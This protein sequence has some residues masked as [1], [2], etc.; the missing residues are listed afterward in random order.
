M[1]ATELSGRGPSDKRI[2]IRAS[3]VGFLV[4]LIVFTLFPK[5][6][7]P[8]FRAFSIPS[9]GMKPSID[10]GQYIIASQVSYGYSRYSF[11][12]LELPIEGRWPSL[13]LPE[14]GD[15][16]VFRGP[17]DRKTFFIKRVVG[18]PGDRIQ[19]VD[20]VLNINGAA[21]KLE[22]IVDK[23]EEVKCGYMIARMTIHRYRESLPDGR[24]HL[25]QKIA[26]TCRF[27]LNEAAEN[28]KVFTVPAEHYFMLGDNRDDSA[29]SRFSAGNGVGYVPLE[30]ILGRVVASF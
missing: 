5:G 6:A 24:S 14:R 9:G 22:R 29:D 26:E 19:M 4:F 2:L 18:L 15:A 11:D 13:W 7:G 16:V 25:I 27:N 30:L 10:V 17:N 21:V 3:L 28:T 23:S 1:S 12:F 8:I 20:G